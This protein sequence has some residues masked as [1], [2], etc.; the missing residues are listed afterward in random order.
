MKSVVMNIGDLILPAEA[1]V[2]FRDGGYRRQLEGARKSV[3]RATEPFVARRP[4]IVGNEVRFGWPT[5]VAAADEGW[6][7]IACWSSKAGMR[8]LQFTGDQWSL[9]E[10]A[11]AAVRRAEGTV[12]MSD[13]RAVELIC[14]DFLA[15]VK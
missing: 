3:K 15:G 13:G 1:A 5:A 9:V 11:I 10:A 7:T 12:F 14:A 2:A 4:T 6:E 8:N